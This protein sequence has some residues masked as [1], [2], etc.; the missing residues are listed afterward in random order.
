MSL[1]G[2]TCIF[3]RYLSHLF[4]EKNNNTFLLSYIGVNKTNKVS[5]NFRT[6][7]VLLVLGLL[8]WS[9]IY[10]YDPKKTQLLIVRFDLKT[11]HI[12]VGRKDIFYLTTHST[13]FIYSY[14]V[15]DIW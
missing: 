5:I 2:P 8:Y 6:L 1:K 13:H 9:Q 3:D 15:S 7:V 4:E 10:F 11:G 14:M 12:S